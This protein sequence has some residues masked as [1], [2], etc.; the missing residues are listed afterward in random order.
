[1]A[2]R[3]GART[4][5]P[6]REAVAV[7]EAELEGRIVSV[8][9]WLALS[10]DLFFFAGW[11]FTF[12]YLRALNYNQGWTPKG[13]GPPSLGFGAA[14]LILVI[15]MAA[16][17]WV[18]VRAAAGSTLFSLLLP[19]SL[20]LG[21]A[22]VLLQGYGMWHLGFG[23]TQGTYASVF[24]G[25]TAVW[26]VHLLA[27]V[28]WLATNVSQSRAG[29]DIIVRPVQAATFSRILVWLAAVGVINY[30]LLYVVH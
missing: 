3:G 27:S 11:W 7:A 4:G 26:L 16:A 14:V 24:A 20:I 2:V 25:L 21:I 22:A 8:G 23:L 10:A 13:V 15:L 5:P 1:M 6:A 12:F 19:V 9:V 30:I 28:L 29:G 18:G 17:Y